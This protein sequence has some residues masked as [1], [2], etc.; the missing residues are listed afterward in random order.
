MCSTVAG[1]RTAVA[2]GA[3]LGFGYLAKTAMLP[4][5]CGFILANLMATH[6]F[7]RGL[8]RVLLATT[9]F[10]LVVAPFIVAISVS[11]HRFTIGDSGRLNYSWSVNKNTRWLHWQGDVLGSGVPVHP[12]RIVLGEPRIYE[13]AG[14]IS[15]TF[16]PWYDPTY[17]YEGVNVYFDLRQQLS[18]FISNGKRLVSVLF[19]ARPSKLVTLLCLTWLTLSIKQYHAKEFSN[20]WII[21]FPAF[22]A[23]LIYAAVIVLP[24]YIAPFAVLSI[25][26]VLRGV[27][28]PENQK[29]QRILKYLTVVLVLSFIIV[30]AWKPVREVFANLEKKRNHQEPHLQWQVAKYLES[31]GVKPGDRVASVGY[32]FLPAW[33]RLGRTKVVAEMPSFNLFWLTNSENQKVIDTFAKTGAKVAVGTPVLFRDDPDVPE[34]LQPGTYVGTPP[35]GWQQIENTEVFVYVLPNSQ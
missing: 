28:M 9:V 7:R 20:L 14:P 32:T 15:G 13:F 26:A 30:T 33:A 27:Q 3:V 23:M 21:V 4:I 18:A 2:L 16:P 25:L 12:T 22:L 29:A 5:G 17:W 6:A 11:K 31:L 10:A 35:S 24:R 19:Q 8:P 1:W 34:N